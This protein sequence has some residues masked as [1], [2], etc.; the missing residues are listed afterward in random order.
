[1]KTR[2]FKRFQN[3]SEK[4]YDVYNHRYV[5]NLDLVRLIF[6]NEEFIIIDNKT[7]RDITVE[8]LLYVRYLLD[9]GQIKVSS[10]TGPNYL[11][12]KF[13]VGQLRDQIKNGHKI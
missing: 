4:L 10:H 7:K 1:M 11:Y 12:T 3:D 9:I 5:S 2:V 6:N 13:E 8:R